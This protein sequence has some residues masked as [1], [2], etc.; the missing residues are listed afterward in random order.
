M[1]LDPGLGFGLPAPEELGLGFCDCE[2]LGTSVQFGRGNG[3]YRFYNAAKARRN[4]Y[5]NHQN[6]PRPRTAGGGGAVAGGSPVKPMAADER[7]PEDMARSDE[8][9]AEREPED[10][11]R[12]DEAVAKKTAT[13]LSS[14]SSSSAASVGDRSSNLDRFLESTTP[15]VPAQYLSKVNTLKLFFFP[16]VS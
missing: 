9:V 14:S 13:A 15:S 6:S 7:E 2:M 11:A 10:M 16:S 5:G 8:A 12:S 3:D 4:H 1:F